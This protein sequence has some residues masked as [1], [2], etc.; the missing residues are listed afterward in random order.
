M[1][2]KVR[3]PENVFCEPE[4]GEEPVSLAPR[5]SMVGRPGRRA[6]GL[7]MTDEAGH[8]CLPRRNAR[9]GTEGTQDTLSLWEWEPAHAPEE[10]GSACGTCGSGAGCCLC[11][12]FR[13]H[14]PV[15]V[16]TFLTAQGLGKNGKVGSLGLYCLVRAC[17]PGILG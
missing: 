6:G 12:W 8:R 13:L 3:P 14:L 5:R 7:R 10:R 2:L 9:N 15:D 1:P 17:G 4:L 11:F 16:Y